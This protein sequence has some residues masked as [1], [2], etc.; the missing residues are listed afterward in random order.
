MK[1]IFDYAL[2]DLEA[3][4]LSQNSWPIEVGLS[5]FR[6]GSIQTWSSLIRPEESW[7]PADWSNQS[8]AVH[9]I[10]R[11]RLADAPPAAEVAEQFL[12][13]VGDMTPVS[14]YP[15]ADRQWLARL[16]E[17]GGYS[18]PLDL[19][20][21]N[22]VSFAH[23]HGYALDQLYETLERRRKPHRAGADPPDIEVFSYDV[24]SIK[25]EP[26]IYTHVLDQLSLDPGRVLFVGD[27][28]QADIEGPRSV[29]FRAIH[30]AELEAAMRPAA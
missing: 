15:P 4:S 24:G 3:S 7:D 14:D 29:G 1:T 21:F 23:F 18:E 27:T 6:D 9:R 8:A 22:I 2:I 11:E 10:R 25:P 19:A 26:E 28:V 30:V 20:D 13:V 16:L 17:A 5:W 12:D